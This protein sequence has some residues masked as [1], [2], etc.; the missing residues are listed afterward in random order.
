[1]ER[2]IR[3]VL[4]MVDGVWC[5]RAEDLE[6]TC[7]G[8][9]TD[10]RQVGPGHLFVPLKGERFDG[11]RFIPDALAKGAV[12]CLFPKDRPIPEE[13]KDRGAPPLILVDD[14]LAALQRLAAAY[15]RE[16]GGRVVAV[17]GSNGK[18]TTKD[19]TAAVLAQ[20]FRVHKTQGNLNN[21]IG[22][23]LTLLSI[24]QEAEVAVVEMGMNHRGEIE[25]L[26]RLARPDIGIITNI[27]EAHLE[28]LGSRE[29][30]AAAKLEIVR[31]LNPGGALLVNGDEPLLQDIP[32]G[33]A[34]LRFGLRPDNDLYLIKEEREGIRQTRF[35]TNRTAGLLTVPLIGRHML[36]NA[37]AAVLCGLYFGL[38]EEQIGR[39]LMSA[40]L[41]QMRTEW[42]EGPNGMQILM[43]AYNASPTSTRAAL[44][45]LAGLEGFTC[46]LALLGDMLELGPEEERWHRE[47]AHHLSASWLDAL[48]TYGSRARWIA[49]EARRL[50]F[51]AERIVTADDVDELVQALRPW[52]KPGT[53]L[54]VKGSRGMRLE[55]II[56]A[57]R[58]D[59]SWT[60]DH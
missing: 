18:T 15:R 37:L 39:G 12:A 25:F 20:Q 38:S 17:T 35:A 23:P 49:D 60:V 32:Y 9:V 43:D 47:L 6:R 26:S 22:L 13:W 24:P 29:A 30:I 11:C 54:L 55:A 5:G 44:E 8:V 51:P 53:V 42:Q 21:H 36:Q 1:M 34:I 52:T 58:G 10:S 57:L 40:R 3:H 59:G 4:K 56:E 7:T 33:G 41:S 2:D 19:L 28:H 16:W 50:G 48:F 45:L 46:K 14:P 31:G 27:G